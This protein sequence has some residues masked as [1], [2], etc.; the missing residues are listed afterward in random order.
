MS[1]KNIC[2]TVVFAVN[3][4]YYVD[5]KNMNDLAFEETEWFEGTSEY[6][7]DYKPY[8]IGALVGQAVG[9]ALGAPYEFG[10]AWRYS[11]DFPSPVLGGAGEMTGGGSFGWKP[12]EFTDDTQM[13]LCIAE[14]LIANDLTYNPNDIFERFVHWSK[15]ARDVGTTTAATLYSGHNFKDA[16]AL[17]H[18]KRGY[19][20]GNGSVMRVSPVG[21]WGSRKSRQETFDTAFEQ[22]RLTHFDPKGAVCAGI[23]AVM[24]RSAI[25]GTAVSVD[26]MIE[27][28]IDAVPIEYA[29][30]AEQVLCTY[31]PDSSISEFGKVSNGTAWVCLAQAVWCLKEA[32]KH[33]DRP[34]GRFSYTVTR[35]IDLGGDTDTVACVAGALAGS[36]YGVQAIPS[37]WTTYLNGSVASLF[38]RTGKTSS[39]VV[40]YSYSDLVDVARK[41]LGFGAVPRTKDEPVAE[42]KIVDPVGVYASNLGGAATVSSDTAVLS[43]CRT[44]GEVDH[45]PVRRSVYLIDNT[46][47]NHSLNS[48]VVD[49]VNTINAWLEE[50]RNVLVHCHAGR[51]R[52]G[53]IL[54]AWHMARYG[55]THKEAHN[56]LASK[57]SLYDP[58]G[59]AVFTRFLDTF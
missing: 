59:N 22:A 46:F 34:D 2:R 56:W 15:T 40:Q 39:G 3:T 11:N 41:L 53:F 38:D 32:E 35:A 26:G 50:G 9:D 8:A 14:S 16:A 13:A 20:A 27:E 45:V 19:S 52:T 37:R 48:A 47:D 42:P 57:W 31:S 21:I 51:S 18:A 5:M 25:T 30:F 36:L 10:P 6:L 4:E 55:S 58:E 44:F 7:D 23:A 28:A 1:S 29:I 24:I 49:C 54:K 17:A 33:E 43:L 12:A